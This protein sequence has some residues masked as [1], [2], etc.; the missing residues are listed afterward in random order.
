MLL[1]LPCCPV[2]ALTRYFTSSFA[3]QP[4]IAKRLHSS[5]PLPHLDLPSSLSSSSLLLEH[6]HHLDLDPPHSRGPVR[7]CLVPITR[8]V[9]EDDSAIT[10]P[11]VRHA[12]HCTASTRP[13]CLCFDPVQN[14]DL[15]PAHV[16]PSHTTQLSFHQ[17][18]KPSNLLGEINSC[19][20]VQYNCH[21]WAKRD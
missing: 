13:R 17:R 20:S 12:P 2:A 7:C 10:H 19:P 1:L 21:C 9:L 3:Y 11:A 16:P 15:R 8:P 5:S 18:A 4:S 14:Y 6:N